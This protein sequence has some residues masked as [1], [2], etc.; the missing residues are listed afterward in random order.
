MVGPLAA[1]VDLFLRHAPQFNAKS[2]LSGQVATIIREL[3]G[4]YV[5]QEE[6]LLRETLSQ[7]SGG[8]AMIERHQGLYP[9]DNQSSSAQSSLDAVPTAGMILSKG[10]TKDFREASPRWNSFEPVGTGSTS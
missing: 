10:P 7:I 8:S 2:R 3:C 4:Q 9:G 5:P 1:L 6:R